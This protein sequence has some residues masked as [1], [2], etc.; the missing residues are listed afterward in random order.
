MVLSV[1]QEPT[2]VSKKK[3]II[4]WLSLLNWPQ[5]I[6]KRKEHPSA[7]SYTTRLFKRGINKIAQKVGEEAVELIIEAKD[8]EK[9]L[10]LEECGDL[11]YHLLVLL[12]AKGVTLEEVVSL[13]R[14]RNKEAGKKH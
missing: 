6:R 11:L 1:I 8:E 5:V 14:S 7:N 12:E 9:E 10:F 4:P 3:I 13:L 2:P